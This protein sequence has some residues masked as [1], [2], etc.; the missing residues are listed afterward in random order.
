MTLRR[1][2]E[3]LALASTLALPLGCGGRH[4]SSE[5]DWLMDAAADDAK[6]GDANGGKG[7]T[8]TGGPGARPGD[9]VPPKSEGGGFYGRCTL[10]GE[11]IEARV[12][13]GSCCEGLKKI[14]REV[15]DGGCQQSGPISIMWCARCGDGECRGVENPCNCPQDC[16]V[17]SGV[18]NAPIRE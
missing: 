11:E 16:A 2:F 3:T 8:C 17:D 13:L 6:S 5:G 15:L 18:T 1:P 9:C 7:R 14:P 4:I 12:V 10:E